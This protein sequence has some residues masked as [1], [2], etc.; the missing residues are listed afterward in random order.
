MAVNYG[1]SKK[2]ALEELITLW[3][4]RRMLKINWKE[5]ITNKEVLIRMKTKM[6]F[7]RNIVIHKLAFAGHVMK[8]LSVKLILTVLK[9]KIKG[10]KEEQDQEGSE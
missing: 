6:K 5:K 3:F 8:G 1:H 2:K 9:G 4:Y 10:K 7:Y